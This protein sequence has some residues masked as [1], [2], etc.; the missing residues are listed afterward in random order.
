MAYEVG[1]LISRHIFRDCLRGR[2]SF[3]P[4]D[5]YNRFG[6]CVGFQP[7]FFTLDHISFQDR[8]VLGY[9]MSPT[10]KLEARKMP[11]PPLI[12]NRIKPMFRDNRELARLRKLTGIT[13]FNADNR[14]D[15][16]N[17]H[18]I[19]SQNEELRSQL[20]DT[21]CFKLSEVES[22]LSRYGSIYLK[23]SNKSLAIGIF[24]LDRD[25]GNHV[26]VSMPGKQQSKV[27]PIKELLALLPEWIGSTPYIMQQTLPLIRIKNQPADIRTSVQRGGQGK[28]QVTGMVARVG[29]IDGIATNVAVGGQAQS[30]RPVL[31][32][33]GVQNVDTVCRQIESMVL[34]AAQ[35]LSEANPGLADLG[36][37][38]AVDPQGR[39][40]IIEVNGRDLRITFRQAKN[41][42]VWR[43]TY[44][45]PMEYASFLLK[46]MRKEAKD[47]SAIAVLTPGVQPIKGRT[48][49]SVETVVRETTERVAQQNRNIFVLG[50]GTNVLKHARP[51]EVRA[52]TRRQYWNRVWG[53][54]HQIRP[55][56]IQVENRPAVLQ[57]IRSLFPD[58]RILLFLHSDTFIQKPYIRPENLRLNLECCDGILTNSAFLKQQISQWVPAS[59]DKI[60]SV[61]LGVDLDRF[62]SLQDPKAQQQRYVKRKQMGL[63][64]K[65]VIL[66]V[67]RF[68]PQKGLHVLLKVFPEILKEHPEAHLLIVGGS[69]YGKEMMTPYVRS[70]KQ[71]TLSF[72]EA[73][74]WLPFVDHTQIQDIYKISD[75]LVT[76]SLIRES[77]GLVNLEGMATGLPVVS[78]AVGGIPEVVK[79]GVTGTLL[80]RRS[81]QHQLA[82]VCNDLLSHPEKMRKQGLAGRRR[83]EE[84]FSWDRTA[85]Q[86]NGIYQ[87]FLEEDK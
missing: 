21:V 86:L 73:T 53:H 6:Q 50:T 69:H 13:L 44:G 51:L 37:D 77:F 2:S 87:R 67:G 7:V 55:A 26:R 10:G 75:L 52:A 48:S 36:F 58:S 45:R 60:E 16:W 22:F 5:L 20:P 39:I 4:L 18:Q 14:L 29:P 68:I 23:P 82:P 15:K 9:L 33:G 11:L 49:G 24:R 46:R 41:L 80:T 17:V 3:E 85:D 47:R 61:H 35:T 28:W 1:V 84:Y 63:V 54:L 40:W 31:K 43:K 81:L 56:L 72:Q 27:Y 57:R 34:K 83:V 78:V 65:K 76:P 64:G 66:F 19:L 70:L 62:K 8:M 59:H 42:D 30:L 32:Q 71:Q 12:H 38:V 25:E 79:D 74:T